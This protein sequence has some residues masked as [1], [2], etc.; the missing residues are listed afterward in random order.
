M[1]VRDVTHSNEN[2]QNTV[3][4]IC[5]PGP[6]D[7]IRFKQVTSYDCTQNNASDFHVEFPFCRI[8]NTHPY[9]HSKN[10]NNSYIE[11]QFYH[12]FVQ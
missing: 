4:I 2:K 10:C 8:L 3:H 5:E 11:T 1:I 6:L 7:F 9:Q 12:Q